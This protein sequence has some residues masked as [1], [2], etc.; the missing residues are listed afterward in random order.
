MIL[1]R[2]NEDISKKAFEFAYMLCR[3]SERG[4]RSF[5]DLIESSAGGI[6]NSIN[7]N[8]Y[9]EAKKQLHAIEGLL[10]LMVSV[11]SLDER[12]HELLSKQSEALFNEL[13][14]EEL[15]F[16]K[17]ILSQEKRPTSI[18]INDIEKSVGTA[19]HEVLPESI[20]NRQSAIVNKIRQSG[21]CRMK[22]IQES[23]P[24]VSERTL[25]YDLQ[26]L[27]FRGMLERIGNAGPATFYRIPV[28]SSMPVKPAKEDI[29]NDPNIIIDEIITDNE[30]GMG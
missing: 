27:V 6:L 2:K 1:D 22:E 29:T 26:S 9:G 18:K 21:N 30:D 25:R 13:L 19:E 7:L 28:S 17:V 4:K 5:A 16:E 20:N 10:R 24:G 8:N 3:I 23:F 11:G 15:E 12:M 14:E